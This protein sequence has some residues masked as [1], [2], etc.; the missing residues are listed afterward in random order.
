MNKATEGNSKPEK[1]KWYKIEVCIECKG[2]IGRDTKTHN[3]GVCPNCGNDSMS[4]VCDTESVILRRIYFYKKL[5]FIFWIVERVEYE[6][7]G[8][9]AKEFLKAKESPNGQVT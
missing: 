9:N 2:R 4:T 3:D 5:F 6:G 8:D 7:K 1:G